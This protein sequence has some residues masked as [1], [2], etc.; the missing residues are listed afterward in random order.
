MRIDTG[1]KSGARLH[2]AAVCVADSLTKYL[3]QSLRFV[4]SVRTLPSRHQLTPIVG[5]FDGAADYF[6][7]LLQRLG[8]VLIKLERYSRVHGPSNKM[9]ILRAPELSG[10]DTI[11]MSDCDVIFVEEFDDLL[12]WQGFQG[13]I[14]DLK[15]LPD[16]ILSAV[17]RLAC[18]PMPHARFTTT[19][20][21]QPSIL[22]CNAG[23]LIFSKQLL[24]PFVAQW[25]RWNDLLLR[26]Q[27]VMENR[28]FFTDQASLCLA[29]EEF[30]HEFRELNV[31]MN[32]P[33]HLKP[34]EYPAAVLATKPKVIH[35]HDAVDY[36]SGLLD[37]TR[38]ESLQAPI[39]GFNERFRE[40]EE[41]IS[42]AAFWD[43]LICTMPNGADEKD[44]FRDYRAGLVNQVIDHAKP[45]SVVDLGCGHSPLVSGTMV[46]S[47]FGID[48]ST[49]A[50]MAATRKDQLG[51]Y[52]R[53]NAIDC[54]IG[55]ADLV[56]MVDL[57]HYFPKIDD[58][59]AAVKN[60]AQASPKMLLISG[61]DQPLDEWIRPHA[62]FHMSVEQILPHFGKYNFDKI[63]CKAGQAFY[64]GRRR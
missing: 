2:V 11:V 50:V 26:H 29:A 36:R 22:Y 30:A 16:T 15:T 12:A 44:V 43:Y 3:Y 23:L 63:G 7:D 54:A 20:D 51:T 55:A 31:E 24:D 62:F 27:A 17:F 5:Y 25:F 53:A 59:W 57:L 18:R 1:H 10:F 13:K 41:L 37:L 60:V 64:L 48:Y 21:E 8:A 14:A 49:E 56:L 9:T 39:A 6:L 52:E 58:V 45:Q 32:Y 34:E 61:L 19:I 38:L 4:L 46:P 40:R 28:A 33:A 42:G 35:Y 47:Y